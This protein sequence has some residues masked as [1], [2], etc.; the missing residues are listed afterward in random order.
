L[1][2]G[3]G[4][5]MTHTNIQNFAKRQKKEGIRTKKGV[6]SFFRREGIKTI[7]RRGKEEE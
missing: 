4:K 2:R 3:S 5:K 6:S 1:K 7:G